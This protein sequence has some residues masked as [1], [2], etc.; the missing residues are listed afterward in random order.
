MIKTL[1]RKQQ[2]RAVV[3]SIVI[4]ENRTW[5][6]QFCDNPSIWNEATCREFVR[7]ACISPHNFLTEQEKLRLLEAGLDEADIEE[8]RIVFK[9]A[10]V[11]MKQ[12]ME[13]NRYF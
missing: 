6:D 2:E 3:E 10:R 7:F 5:F 1:N 9:W 11:L 4:K 12:S 8:L 13:G